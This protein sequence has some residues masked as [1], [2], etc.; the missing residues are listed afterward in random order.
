MTDKV[1]YEEAEIIGVNDI[2]Y[3]NSYT[4]AIN[5]VMGGAGLKK[6]AIGNLTGIDQPT[7][8]AVT[9]GD[10]ALTMAMLATR[11]LT[12]D[13]S[14]APRAPTL[15]TGT[16]VHA[17]LAVGQSIDWS[18]INIGNQNVTITAATD[19]TIIPSSCILATLASNTFRTICTAHNVAV[20][21]RLH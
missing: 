8:E 1:L 2:D 15:P 19:S 4:L 6:L 17:V 12:M 13:S 18:F 20:T 3:A 10:T 11:I 5:T 21:Y 14:I 7:P 9:D 16:E